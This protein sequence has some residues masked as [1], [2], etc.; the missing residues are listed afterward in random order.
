MNLRLVREAFSDRS[1]IG[2]LYVD[3]VFQCF[4]LEDVVRDQKIA[5]ETCIPYGQYE[6]VITFS[7][8]FNRE[9]PLVKNVPGFDGI[10]IH[11]GNTDVNTHGCILVGEVRLQDRIE[12]SKVAFEKLFARLKGAGKI[13]LEIVEPDGV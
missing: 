7:Q 9:L 6:V 12:Q 13:S 10:R 3:N 4:T 11:P 2:S 1:T 8:K 5:G